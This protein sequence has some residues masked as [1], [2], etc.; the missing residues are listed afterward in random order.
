MRY[1]EKQQSWGWA[2]ATDAFLAGVGGG[3]FL[4]SFIFDVL[5]MHESVARIGALVG[6]LLILLGIFFLLADL[7]SITRVYR[8]FFTPTTLL[9]SWM[10]RGAWILTAFVVLALL[11]ALPSFSLF[12]WLPWSRSS[13]AGQ[14]IGVIAALL[15]ILV[16]VYPGFLLGVVKGIPFWNNTTLPPLFFLSGL[17]TGVALLALIALFYSESFGKDGFHLLGASD[18]ALICVVLVVLAAYVEIVRQ[19]S[20]TAVISVRL[21]K[22]PMFI[23]GVL[24]LGLLIPLAILIPSIWLDNPTTLRILAGFTGVFILVGGLLLR[25]SIIRAGVYATLN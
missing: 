2:I 18:I 12:E 13:G 17:N 16:V 9:T 25:Y 20:I 8:L 4:F 23:G 14:G 21:L 6:P 5:D 1:E 3:T 22:T 19:A 24:I 10:A 11:Y 7:G 15:S